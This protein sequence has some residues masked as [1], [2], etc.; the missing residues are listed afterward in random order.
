M[1]HRL[2]W[3]RNNNVGDRRMN[4]KELLKAMNASIGN[5]LRQKNLASFVDVLIDMGKLK[6]SDYEDWRFG[7]TPFLERVIQ[8]NLASLNFLHRSF[9]SYCGKIGL[10][11]SHTAY[12][13]WGK[14]PKHMLRFSKSGDHNLER[15]YATHYLTKAAVKARSAPASTEQQQPASTPAPDTTTAVKRATNAK[16]HNVCDEREPSEWDNGTPPDEIFLS[17]F[18]PSSEEE[19]GKPVKLGKTD[20]TR[21]NYDDLPF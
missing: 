14:G 10:K 19:T 4:R 5:V 18:S 17:I 12:M 15:A 13:R 20:R 1:R 2:H 11:P 8:L 9:V 3:I 7:R 16:A 6:T 21:P